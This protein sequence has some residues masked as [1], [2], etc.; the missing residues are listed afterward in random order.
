M[1]KRAWLH[2]LT[3]VCLVAII[4]MVA[5][6]SDTS[7]GD[8]KDQPKKA[9]VPIPDQTLYQSDILISEHGMKKALIKFE[10]LEKYQSRDSTLMTD[11]DATFF[12]S[13]GRVSSTLI[14][15]SGIV[16]EKTNKLQVWGNVKIVSENGVTLEADSLFWDQQRDSITTESFVK[17]TKRGNIQTGYGLESDSRLTNVRIKKRVKAKFEDVEEIKRK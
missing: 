5:A 11:I 6:C 16:R 3:A 9:V 14:S 15:D 4:L 2:I 17:I 10:Y 13:L 7:S 8:S 1:K 12:D